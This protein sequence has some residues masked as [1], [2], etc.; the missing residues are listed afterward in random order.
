MSLPIFTSPS[1]DFTDI[2]FFE[3]DVY[4]LE[5]YAYDPEGT[6]IQYQVVEEFGDGALFYITPD[7]NEL[8]F[9]TDPDFEDP[10][11]L[12]HD[13]VYEVK[14]RAEDRDSE[15]VGIL[16]AELIV[17]RAEKGLV[18]ARAG[19]QRHD[20]A[21]EEEGPLLAEALAATQEE[22]HGIA[23]D[24]EGVAEPR[25]AALEEGRLARMEPDRERAVHA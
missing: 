17:G 21:G 2:D 24:V 4:V 15:L 5:L 23:V 13:N 16:R 19:E 6:E 10:S 18:C 12:D 25:Q 3:F 22:A 7:Y 9:I 20:L 1:E 14:V 11:D 8:A